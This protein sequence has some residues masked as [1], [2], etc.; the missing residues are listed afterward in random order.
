MTSRARLHFVRTGTFFMNDEILAV[1]G[2]YIDHLLPSRAEMVSG[3]VG[4]VCLGSGSVWLI[5]G[6][7]FNGPLWLTLSL[8]LLTI[9]VIQMR[10]WH[11]LRRE[12]VNFLRSSEAR[13]VK[14]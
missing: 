2:E 9:G 8:V 4:G 12:R 7:L 6:W 11:R 14:N 13:G 1:S 5:T 3:A 10:K